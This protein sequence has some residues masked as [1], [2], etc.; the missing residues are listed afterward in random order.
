MPPLYPQLNMKQA[1]LHIGLSAWIIQ[2]GNYSDFER[3]TAA[4]FALEFYS[5]RGLAVV[6]DSHEAPKL[7]HR[8]DAI[9]SARGV[10]RFCSD[11]VWVVDFGDIM[12]YREEQPPRGISAGVVVSGELYLGIDPFFYFERLFRF[13]GMP[14]LIYE[15]EIAGI[16]MVTAP[17]VETSDQSGRKVLVR[18]VTKL[19]RVPLSKTDAW[20]DDGGHGEYV[21]ECRLVSTGAL[22][23]F[24]NESR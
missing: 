8:F 2:D 22:R 3:G 21:L 18:D 6:A 15:W 9:Y 16:Q 7:D 17:L 11:E 19:T 23:R 20:N 14:P 12:A 5:E 13:P 10:V 24:N 4:R 1:L